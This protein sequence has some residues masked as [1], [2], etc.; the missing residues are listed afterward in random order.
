MEEIYA[1]ALAKGV[2]LAE[3]AVSRTMAFV[4]G[5]PAGSVPSMQRDILNGKPSELEH[6]NGAVV[7]MGQ[8]SGVP[9]PINAFIY[10]SLLPQERRAR[11]LQNA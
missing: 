3:D 2:S 11:S 8:E 10:N 6:Q 7:R 1:V 9:T 4:D 5:L